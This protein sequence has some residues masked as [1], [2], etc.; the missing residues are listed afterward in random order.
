VNEPTAIRKERTI[1]FPGEVLVK[2]G[3]RVEADTVVVR[4]VFSPKRIFFVESATSLRIT[5]PE[6][7]EYA[8]KRQGDEVLEGDILARRRVSPTETVRR[9]SPVDGTIDRISTA[10]GHFIIVEEETDLRARRVNVAKELGLEK[11]ELS[12]Y[13]KKKVGQIVEKGGTIAELPLLAGFRLK[14]CKSPI[15]AE[16]KSIDLDTGEV[17]LQRPHERIELKAGLPGLVEEVILGKGAIIKTKGRRIEGAIGFGKETFGKLTCLQGKDS[18]AEGKIVVG[19]KPITGQE[20]QALKEKGAKGAVFSELNVE[21]IEPLFEEEVYSGVTGKVDR[22]IVLLLLDGFGDQPMK[23]DDWAFFRSLEGAP[24]YLSG[25][26]QIR[27][28]V[29]RPELIVSSNLQS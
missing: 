2:R 24:A 17:V 9:I 4:G 20:I 29:V 6:I 22:G 21:D 11:S 16:I 13:M 12:R 19:K 23:E 25:M 7:K 15:Y 28:G 10:S 3:D 14:R 5:P 1:Y 8:L 18:T 26:T 27:A